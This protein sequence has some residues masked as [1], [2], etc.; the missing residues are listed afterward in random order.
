MSCRAP[1]SPAA[2]GCCLPPSPWPPQRSSAAKSSPRMYPPRSRLPR[3]REVLPFRRT[4][5]VVT[6]S[7]SSVWG[8]ASCW[9]RPASALEHGSWLFG[10]SVL[11][12]QADAIRWNHCL[13]SVLSECFL[14]LRW[15]LRGALYFESVGCFFLRLIKLICI[16]DNMRMSVN[17]CLVKTV[18]KICQTSFCFQ[19]SLS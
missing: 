16:S 12:A 8:S 5:S 9:R 11:S 4:E 7:Q 10:S 13:V 18:G 15:Q 3:G 19:L 14:G 6:T 2:F 17:V 1:Q